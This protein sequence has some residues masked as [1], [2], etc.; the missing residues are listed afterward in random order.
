MKL[1]GLKTGA[2][3]LMLA[4]M[5]LTLTGCFGIPKGTTKSVKAGEVMIQATGAG[6]VKV[7]AQ[8][9]TITFK[10]KCG[11]CGFEPAEQTIP[12]PKAG[13]PYTINWVCPKCGN[14][15]KV[16]IEVVSQ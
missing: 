14:K 5:V 12:I 15:Q 16:T 8:A 3:V 7:D 6:I 13:Q 10:I 2:V 11:R 9:Q 1:S 4:G